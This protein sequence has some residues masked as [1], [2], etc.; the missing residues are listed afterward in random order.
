M[1]ITAN[2]HCMDQLFKGKTP[3]RCVCMGEHR[4]HV[5]TC[6]FTSKYLFSLQVVPLSP[7]VQHWGPGSL[8]A[9]VPSGT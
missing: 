2:K 1:K 7:L 9:V 8:G 3:W 4:D 5:I 6:G